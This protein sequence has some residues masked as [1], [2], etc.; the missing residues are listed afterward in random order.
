MRDFTVTT[1]DGEELT[2]S[3][4]LKEKQAVVL[5]F[6]YTG[7]GPCKNEFPLLQAAYEAYSD[8]IEVITMNPTDISQDTVE[9]IKASRDENGL[10]MPMAVFALISWLRNPYNGNKAEV[11]VNTISKTECI[12]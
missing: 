12:F 4:I 7:C 1:V 5:N 8:K 3:E 6:W 9:G 2:L 11:K 10:T